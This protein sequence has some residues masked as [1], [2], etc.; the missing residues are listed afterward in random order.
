MRSDGC[1]LAVTINSWSPFPSLSRFLSTCTADFKKA[2]LMNK[3][4]T[5]KEMLAKEMPT[6]A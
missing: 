4:K 5:Y 6:C 3:N 1:A 2:D